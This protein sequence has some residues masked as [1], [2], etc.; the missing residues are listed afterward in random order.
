M[1]VQD[2]CEEIIISEEQI[3]DVIT[4]ISNDINRDYEGEEVVFV[5]TLKGAF[6][7]ASDLLKQIKPSSVIDFMQIST[8]GDSH[9]SNNVFNVKLDLKTD[10]K[11]KNVIVI[12]DIVDSGFT[13]TCLMEYLSKKE[14]KTLKMATFLNKQANRKFE[15]TPDYVGFEL[16]DD[17][18]VAGYGLDY[19]QLY[20]NIP[21]L[22][23]LKKEIYCKD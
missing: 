3:K 13:S 20:R 2:Y 23:K 18:F 19:S 17:A 7:F 15:F 22:F 5:V 11:D 21:F 14:P 1:K 12:E 6:M 8:Y 16:E 4:R 10:I 9:V